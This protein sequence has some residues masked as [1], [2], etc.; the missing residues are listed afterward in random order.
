LRASYVSPNQKSSPVTGPGAVR[1][2]GE[3]PNAA[4]L[5]SV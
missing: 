5:P 2:T 3:V 1:H 4:V